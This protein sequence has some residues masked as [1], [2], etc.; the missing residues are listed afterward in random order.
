MGVY[1]AS[2]WQVAQAIRP[3]LKESRPSVCPELPQDDKKQD[4]TAQVIAELMRRRLVP[5][6]MLKDCCPVSLDPLRVFL[7]LCM[8]LVPGQTCLEVFPRTA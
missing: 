5:W 3:E 1:W 2:F 8:L 4:V 6:D 7:F